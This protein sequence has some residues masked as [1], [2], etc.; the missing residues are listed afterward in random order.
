[1]IITYRFDMTDPDDLEGQR[2]TD[3]A[4]DLRGAISD[5]DEWTRGQAKHGRGVWRA[6]AL[7]EIRERLWEILN[8]RGVAG[9]FE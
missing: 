8:D 2:V 3:R 9:L 7:Q 5:L 1:M 6:R 4:L